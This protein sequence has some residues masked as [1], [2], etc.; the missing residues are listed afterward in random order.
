MV[1]THLYKSVNSDGNM[2]KCMGKRSFLHGV[3]SQSNLLVLTSLWH[4]AVV[5]V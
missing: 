1:E 5:L 3:Y 4:E 2:V